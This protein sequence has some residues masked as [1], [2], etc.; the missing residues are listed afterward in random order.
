MDVQNSRHPSQP[1]SNN[2]SFLPS[3]PSMWV[4]YV[5]HPLTHL[6]FQSLSKFKS[7]RNCDDLSKN[8]ET[9]IF[10]SKQIIS[11]LSTFTLTATPCDK[12]KKVDFF[13]VTS[14]FVN[15]WNSHQKM[16]SQ[17]NLQLPN[18]VHTH[19]LFCRA[20]WWNAK[21]Y[22]RH[23]WVLARRIHSIETQHWKW[24]YCI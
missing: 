20:L 24:K 7:K 19:V 5:Y 22:S 16:R 11:C 9:I 14:A 1:T 15:L 12:Y 17:N 21:Q 13:D 23:N 4:S 3:S 2:I 18:G 6:I 10:K 8:N